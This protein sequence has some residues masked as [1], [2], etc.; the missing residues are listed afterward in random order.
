[1]IDW[2]K[3]MYSLTISYQLLC[4]FQS[5][6]YSYFLGILEIHS[7]L[8]LC[9]I[10]ENHLLLWFWLSSSHN[11]WCEILFL[12][13]KT[14]HKLW[15]LSSFE[16]Q[17]NENTFPA[18]QNRSILRVRSHTVNFIFSVCSTYPLFDHFYFSF[19]PHLSLNSVFL[20]FIFLAQLFFQGWRHIDY[21]PKT[22]LFRLVCFCWVLFV[23]TRRISWAL[24][25]PHFPFLCYRKCGL[26]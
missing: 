14:N 3:W 7:V 2:L 11:T 19:P 26:R 18:Q 12:Q 6:P 1:M 13:L 17:I 10:S 20:P 5:P 8:S 21:L 22:K 4:G 16:G 23:H 15:F 25:W 9:D 24:S